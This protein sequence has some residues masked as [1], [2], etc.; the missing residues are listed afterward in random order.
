M[1]KK[2][3]TEE[4]KLAAFTNWQT[5]EEYNKILTF[6]GARQSILPIEMGTSDISDKW[7]TFLK[8]LLE[9]MI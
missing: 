8:E 2:K 6:T 3:Q 7:D 9:L 5:S 1:V 4:Q